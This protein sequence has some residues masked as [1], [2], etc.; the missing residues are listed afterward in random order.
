M[1][2]GAAARVPLQSARIPSASKAPTPSPQRPRRDGTRTAP[3]TSAAESTSNP[4]LPNCVRRDPASTSRPRHRTSARPARAGRHHRW[5]GSRNARRPRS[6]AIARTTHPATRARCHRPLAAP[7]CP[8]SLPRPSTETRMP[9][10]AACAAAAFAAAS[11]WSVSSEDVA[12][13][14]TGLAHE[15]DCAGDG[16]VRAMSVDRHHVGRER[17]E[18]ERDVGGIVGQRRDG[19]CVVG[20][21]DQAHLPARAFAQQRGEFRARLQQARRRQIRGQRAARQIERDRP[22]ACGSATPVARPASTRGPRVRARRARRRAA[23]RR[24]CRACARSTPAPSSQGSRCASTD[25][26]HTLSRRP[27][28][29]HN[30]AI[31]GNASSAHSHDGRRKCSVRRQHAHAR[32][33]NGTAPSAARPSAIASGSG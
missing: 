19:E 8:A 25:A 20:E 27:R 18:E 32:L 3:A 14:E 10:F 28:C 13:I 33:R 2:C 6:R 24:A 5:T 16:A 26:R 1:P 22:A 15:L 11:P 17:I 12:V 29:H 31:S 9:C 21:C 7:R 4:R 23:R 30:H